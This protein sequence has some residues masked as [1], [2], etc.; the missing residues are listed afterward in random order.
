MGMLAEMAEADREHAAQA[1][2]QAPAKD[3]LPNAL[4]KGLNSSTVAIT[5]NVNAQPA[6]DFLHDNALGIVVVAA[7]LAMWLAVALYK[8]KSEGA[9]RLKMALWAIGAVALVL[10]VAKSNNPMEDMILLSL[11]AAA[12]W[13]YKGF[14]KKV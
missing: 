9:R 2:A 10:G 8:S 4:A 7:A 3:T 1:Q 14:K 12:V 5:P 6:R 11:L 13:V